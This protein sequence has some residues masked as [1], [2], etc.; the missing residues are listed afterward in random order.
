MNPRPARLG[1]PLLLSL[2]LGFAALVA[3][4]GAQAR[5]APDTDKVVRASAPSARAA[6]DRAQG[7]LAG[8]QRGDATMALRQLALSKAGLTGADR[9]AADRILARPSDPGDE[10]GYGANLVTTTCSATVCVHYTTTGDEAS[11]AE[12]AA[13]TLAE[14]SA[15][16]DTY[17]T[18]GYRA[19]KQD[20]TQGGNA[21]PDVYIAE[22]G[23]KGLY[24][25]CTTEDDVPSN[26]PYDVSAYCVVDN[27]YSSEEFPTNTP[28]EN[29][30]V[31]VAHEYFHA[32]QYAYDVFEDSWFLEATAAWV[33]DILYD[34][35]DDNLQYLRDSPLTLP[36]A[37]MDQFN[38]DNGFHYGVW[39]F[40]RYLSEKY[41]T[42]QG[43]MPT[44][45]RD[46][47]RRTDGAAGGPDDYSWQAVERVLQARGSSAAKAFALF[48]DANR[49]PAKSYAEGAANSYPQAPLGNFRLKSGWY[50]TTIDH[51]ASATGRF[52]PSRRGSKLKISVDLADKA[53]SPVAIVSIYLKSGAVRTSAI[54]LN[55]A[56][57]GSKTVAFSRSKV[58]SVEVTL[59]NGSGRF[60]NCYDFATPFSCG[61]A[62]PL[63]DNRVFK[64][65]ATLRF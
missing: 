26:G 43:G 11:T 34:D 20:G 7:V 32:V 52:T 41:P 36:R 14:A 39:I 30:Q 61:G 62:A 59:V 63:D 48:A 31:T 19:P 45:V 55:G 10:D 4:P 21:L 22:I 1:V 24:G 54:A 50:V 42:A 44:I 25:Y 38:R 57:N 17:V 23:D 47:I 13:A 2:V 28:L 64:L 9:A 35:V 8:R 33:E 37:S 12:F 3:P 5:P 15:V 18:A 56:G 49:R 40:F 51:L 6:L 29:L 60:R 65:S 53:T 27:D 58:S 16:N 46:I